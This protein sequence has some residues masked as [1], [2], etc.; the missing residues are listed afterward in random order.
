[1]RHLHDPFLHLPIRID[2][3]REGHLTRVRGHGLTV[4]CDSTKFFSTIVLDPVHRGNL[5]GILG[6]A[7]EDARNDFE[8]PSGRVATDVA[9]LASSFEVSG[10]A[11]CKAL[12]EPVSR[13]QEDPE[14]CRQQI[15]QSLKGCLVELKMEKVFMAAC[16]WDVTTGEDVCSSINAVAAICSH[17]G[18][19]I[20][21]HHC[22]VSSCHALLAC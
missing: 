14:Q 1:M 15:P 18:H 16:N 11:E 22:G 4:Y 8:L 7:N 5:I 6:D 21:N 9:E 3:Y 10:Y 13:P 19:R 12:V 20:E 2:V 17:H